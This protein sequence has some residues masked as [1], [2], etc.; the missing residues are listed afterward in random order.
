M[1]QHLPLIALCVI[2][3]PAT[4]FDLPE[5][6]AGLWEIKMTFE[7]RSAP[8]II[9]RQCI[10]AANDKLMHLKGNSMGQG[11]CSKQDTKQ[12]GNTFVVD[13]ICQIGPMTAT[14]QGEVT[15]NF[16]SAYTMKMTSRLARTPAMPVANG[17]ANI[18]MDLTLDI[19]I[20]AK[21][22]SA[23]QADQRPGDI[24]MADGNKLNINEPPENTGS[25]GGRR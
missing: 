23:C 13:S 3:S 19:T 25:V 21:W 24:I 4:G 5:R 12:V 22:L 8:P 10:D 1:R 11:T 20:D 14:S 17:A 6:R 2:A 16:D 9:T 15:G 7:G 18:T